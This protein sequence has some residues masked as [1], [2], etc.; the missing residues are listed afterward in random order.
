MLP[1]ACETAI[2]QPEE[3]EVIVEKFPH[4]GADIQH[5]S[6]FCYHHNLLSALLIN[7]LYNT[8][9]LARKLLCNGLDSL[10]VPP[11][12]QMWPLKATVCN[13]LSLNPVPLLPRERHIYI[14]YDTITLSIRIRSVIH[15]Y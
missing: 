14:H 4:I 5:I 2:G 1:T 8:N 15:P 7:A 9:E 12:R 6:L 11:S 3:V 13:L 10:P